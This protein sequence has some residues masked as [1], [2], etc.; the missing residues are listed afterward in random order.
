MLLEWELTLALVEWDQS[1]LRKVF[2]IMY[3]GQDE[4]GNFLPFPFGEYIM[5]IVCKCIVRICVEVHRHFVFN[6]VFI[7]LFEPLSSGKIANLSR[8]PSIA[9]KRRLVDA[10]ISYG[11]CHFFVRPA[12]SLRVSISPTILSFVVLSGI[13]LTHEAVKRSVYDTVSKILEFQGQ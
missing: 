10:C 7:M 2:P 11:E 6:V 8:L 4:S 3:G 1:L 13:P 9:T 12:P 5:C